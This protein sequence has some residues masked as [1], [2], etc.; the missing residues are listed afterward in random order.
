MQTI[1]QMKKKMR[2]SS[3]EPK[4]PRALNLGDYANGKEEADEKK[5]IHGL[6]H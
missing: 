6:G 1:Q 3:F 2:S 4:F 5:E